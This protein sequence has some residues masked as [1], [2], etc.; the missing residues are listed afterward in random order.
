MKKTQWV[1]RTAVR[2][3]Y[4]NLA[5]NKNGLPVL[6][7][8]QQ[9][10]DIQERG[11][12]D[13]DIIWLDHEF[14]TA[15]KIAPEDVVQLAYIRKLEQAGITREEYL[16]AREENYRQQLQSYFKKGLYIQRCDITT[17]ATMLGKYG[18]N[19][20]A[21]LQK[22]LKK[23]G[24]GFVSGDNE[25]SGLSH[26]DLLNVLLV[27][28][29]P[30]E[31]VSGMGDVPQPLFNDAD[32]PLEIFTA[33]FGPQKLTKVI[34]AEYIKTAFVVGAND[35][36]EIANPEFNSDFILEE[37][38]YDYRA[39][40]E[41]VKKQM[42]TNY[43]VDTVYALESLIVKH[44]VISKSY[45][46]YEQLV[47]IVEQILNERLEVAGADYENEDLDMLFFIEDSHQT[48]YECQR[49]PLQA[50]RDKLKN[51]SNTMS[52]EEMEHTLL[53]LITESKKSLQESYKEGAIIDEKDIFKECLELVTEN[54]YKKIY[55]CSSANDIIGELETKRKI[56]DKIDI[57]TENYVNHYYDT[58]LAGN[59]ENRLKAQQEMNTSGNISVLLQYAIRCDADIAEAF[60]RYIKN[61]DVSQLSEEDCKD[62]IVKIREEAKE[63]RKAKLI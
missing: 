10:L 24:F 9:F 60:V 58:I 5:S 33:Y 42:E 21:E 40:E 47:T 2:P 8:D 25:L 11:L 50:V 38:A 1:H 15:D 55:Y 37:G 44:Y 61:N 32:N 31:C 18:K 57:E 3:M 22:I 34:P 53:A 63:A 46:Q 36:I 4:L 27:L 35:R 52:P 62:L 19:P 23:E 30:E 13:G 39:L 26:R 51:E 43:S 20:E 29:I 6:L 54:I 17:T 12:P 48:I 49:T 45:S 28:E 14:W 56:I 16:Q 41:Y 59:K 7:N